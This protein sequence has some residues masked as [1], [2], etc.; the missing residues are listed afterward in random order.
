MY[1]WRSLSRLAA[2][3]LFAALS[4]CSFSS[5]NKVALSPLS[6]SPHPPSIDSLNKDSPVAEVGAE[7]HQR[8]LALY[9]GEYNDP[10]LER[11][12]AKI[13]GQLAGVID[14]PDTAYRITILNS[15]SINA[16]ALP[17]GYVYVTRGLLALAND[18]SEV[19]AVIA[20][21]MAHITANHGLLRQEK[22]AQME[23]A[24]TV[25]GQILGDKL[26]EKQVQLRSHLTLA[27]F[28][29][30][31][32][33]Q[34]DEI[35]IKTITLAGYDP[36]AA[37]R[38][39]TRMEAYNS[40]RSISGATN[41][42]LDFLATHPA[43]PQRV[44][45]AT[46]QARRLS[47]PGIGTTD[48]DFFLNGIDGMLYGDSENEGYIRG[49]NFIHPR[50]AIMFRVPAGFALDNSKAAVVA[51]GPEN[52]AIRFDSVASSSETPTPL[53]YIRSGW[54]SGLE[55][56]SIRTFEQAGLQAASARA[57]SD[58][59]R[60]VVVVIM[61]KER[62]Y[63]FLTA[64]PKNTLKDNEAELDRVSNSVTSSFRLLS[65]EQI[66]QLKPLRLR[67]IQ[68]GKGQSVADLVGRM[69]DIDEGEAVF[70]LLNGLSPTARLVEGMRVKI[71]SE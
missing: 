21:E 40:F 58:K 30:N 12:V 57:Q 65:R 16:F 52:F 31:Q 2:G 43:T 56:G 67:I 33:L 27:Q 23:V 8:I 69:H 38:F 19:A 55:S 14:S 39:L 71:I 15:P 1:G 50:L 20:H 45:L 46:A 66:A 35:G 17:G 34:A 49:L 54:V 3:L 68:V 41:A 70:R 60:F 6:P 47:A 63:R 5:V 42:K 9:G 53:D 48:R 11:M 26:A 44:K 7:Q 59:W 51:N 18:S 61:V 62:I 28:S 29:R 25:A 13:V 64:A 37:A 10:K 32:E 36:F 24:S 22:Q 4:G